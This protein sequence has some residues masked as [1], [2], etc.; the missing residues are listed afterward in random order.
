VEKRE[1]IFSNEQISDK[2]CSKCHSLKLDLT[3]RVNKLNTQ[4]ERREK[5]KE[6][7]LKFAKM[8]KKAKA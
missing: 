1:S 4:T 3:R 7:A 2:V 5:A 6:W 8:A